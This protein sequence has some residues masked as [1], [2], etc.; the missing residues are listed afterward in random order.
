MQLISVIVS[1]SDAHN[2]FVITGKGGAQIRELQDQSGANI[3][4][5]RDD[6][7]LYE[8]PVDIS[9]TAEAV[10]KAKKLIDELLHPPST[11]VEGEWQL[12][13][14]TTSAV[15]D[16]MFVDIYVDTQNIPTCRYNIQHIDKRTMEKLN[17]NNHA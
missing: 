7:L 15:V 17:V 14:V 13:G 6:D 5:S 10:E 4:I 8:T 9:G 2:Y 12:M 16:T 3:R 1:Y 11:I